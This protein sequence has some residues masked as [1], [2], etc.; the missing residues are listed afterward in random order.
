M[1]NLNDIEESF[2]YQPSATNKEEAK[3]RKK[4]LEELEDCA[5][6]W[7]ATSYQELKKDNKKFMKMDQ[8]LR[9]KQSPP[10]A[11]I[12]EVHK[13]MIPDFNVI[14]Q[15]LTWSVFNW[16]MSPTGNNNTKVMRK[17]YLTALWEEV[18][19]HNEKRKL[20]FR[21][22][23]TLFII[24]ADILDIIQSVFGLDHFLP[25]TFYT[26]PT[27]LK[28]HIKTTFKDSL[29]DRNKNIVLKAKWN[30]ALD[31]SFQSF[32]NALAKEGLCGIRIPAEGNSKRDKFL[33]HP[34]IHE[35]LYK[36]YKVRLF[37]LS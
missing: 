12:A 8:K 25:W 9:H 19:I 26:T 36:T 21:D 3:E 28:Q 29:V 35:Q 17:Q 27:N 33:L 18:N 22:C 23:P 1:S 2:N 7:A 5:N 4:Q 15:G 24:R 10:Q 11:V 32:I 16:F 37:L 20:L 30:K 31:K 13:M 34:V 6:T 14:L